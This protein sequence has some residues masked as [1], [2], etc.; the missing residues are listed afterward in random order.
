M[1]HK[2]WTDAEKA[3]LAEIAEGRSHKEIQK[4]M[5]EKFSPFTPGQIKAALKRYNIKTGLTGRFEKNRIPHNK[6]KKGHYHPGSEKTWFKKGRTPHNQ[7]PVGS[8]ITTKDG[9]IMKKV[10]EPSSWEFKH[11]VAWEEKNGKVP[12]GKALIFLDNDTTNC[13][14]NNLKLVTRRELLEMNRKGLHSNHAELTETGIN[15]AKLNIKI[16]EKR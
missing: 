11:R 1:K 15:I 2:R 4:L 8:E 6:G 10:G 12:E 5:S 14:I 9:Y 7:L 13:D 16:S 3:Y